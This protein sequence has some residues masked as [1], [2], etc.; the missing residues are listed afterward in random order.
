MEREISVAQ[1]ARLTGYTEGHI[2]RLARR[3]TI[4]A[5]R[6]GQRVL[7]IDRASLEAY[8]QEMREL[9]PQKHAPNR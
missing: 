6:V 7:L 8:T 4:E 1:A 2:R 9:G 5:R 3:G